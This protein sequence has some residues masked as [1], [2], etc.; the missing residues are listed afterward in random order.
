MKL[1]LGVSKVRNMIFLYPFAIAHLA[2]NALIGLDTDNQLIPH[3]LALNQ[4]MLLFCTK[5]TR[6]IVGPNIFPNS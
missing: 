4:K 3:T 5:K 2:V 1:E 6:V